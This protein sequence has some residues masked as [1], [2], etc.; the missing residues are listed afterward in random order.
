MVKAAFEARV[1]QEC[2]VMLGRILFAGLV[3]FAA[4]GAQAAERIAARAPSTDSRGTSD[5]GWGTGEGAPVRLQVGDPAPGFSYIG[6]D[7]RWHGFRQL[8]AHGPVLLVFGAR[9]E[10]LRALDRTR[11]VLVDLGVHAVAVLDMRSGSA[12]RLVKRLEFQC[13]VI[14]DS[15]CVIGG[16]YG[17][18]DPDTQRHGPSYFVLDE[19]GRVRGV[20]RGTLPAPRKLVAISAKSLGRALPESAQA[21]SR[22]E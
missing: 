1:A 6:L 21:L 17:S 7:G 14:V 10:D 16:L 3:V 5:H 8:F 20:G 15:Q 19:T 11:Q 18:L 12:T 4:S 9:D 22:R 2:D 13:D